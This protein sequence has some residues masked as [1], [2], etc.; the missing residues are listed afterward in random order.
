V[1]DA[2]PMIPRMTASLAC[3]ALLGCTE[4]DHPEYHPVTVTTVRTSTVVVAPP[5]AR[6]GAYAPSVENPESFF[7]R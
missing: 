4:T 3:I 7:T 6:S 5:P 1:N 2:K